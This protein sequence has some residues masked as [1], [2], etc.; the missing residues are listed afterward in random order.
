[1]EVAESSA[2]HKQRYCEELLASKKLGQNR[3]VLNHAGYVTVNALHPRQY[4]ALKIELY[5][6]LTPLHACRI[7][8]ATTRLERRGCL[9]RSLARCFVRTRRN[10]SLRCASG[11]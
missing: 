10:G 9:S 2:E 6:L 1:M 7:R 11:T 8:A 4:F 5:E 3:F